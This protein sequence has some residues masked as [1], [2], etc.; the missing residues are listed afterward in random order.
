[1][2]F[3]DWLGNV[4]GQAGSNI[5]DSIGE[6][7]DKF[8]TT[9][10]ERQELQIVLDK[11]RLEWKKL[12]LQGEQEYLKD[13]AS[14]REMY[15]KDSSL[16]KV[17]AVTFLLGYLFI[18]AT[19]IVVIFGWFGIGVGVE[20]DA[21]KSSLITMVF[22]ALS[23]KVATITDFLFGGSKNKDDS[24]RRM[25]EAFASRQNDQPAVLTDNP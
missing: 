1:M 6:T 22:T 19:M 14:A 3:G 13:R 11:Q 10:Q 18:S 21:I 12:E 7:V 20:L 5:I 15:M 24:E 25:A 4:F 9:D 23:T 16:Q 8:V 17:F 2:A